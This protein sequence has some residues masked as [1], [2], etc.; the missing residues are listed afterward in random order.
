MGLEMTEK[1]YE[2]SA[3]ILYICEYMTIN[4]YAWVTLDELHDLE[5]AEPLLV[6][7]ADDFINDHYGFV[8]SKFATV[9]IQ[10]SWSHWPE[11]LEDVDND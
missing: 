4:H 6:D 9:D 2:Y 3:D 8:P 11:E 10:I 1:T 7:Q 5:D